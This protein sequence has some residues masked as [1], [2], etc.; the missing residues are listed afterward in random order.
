[1]SSSIADK[2]CVNAKIEKL[3]D[4]NYNSWS[5]AMEKAFQAVKLWDCVEGNDSTGTAGQRSERDIKAM[6]AITVNVSFKMM[7]IIR[8]KM[9]AEEMW[10][11]LKSRYHKKSVAAQRR[12]DHQLAN[13]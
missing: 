8:G 2:L 9:S 3:E 13:I 6:S 1:M 5:F 11:A 7:Q 10:T 4:D 12:L